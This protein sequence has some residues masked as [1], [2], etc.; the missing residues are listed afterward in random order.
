MKTILACASLLFAT[1]VHA[2]PVHQCAAAASKQAQ[3]LLVFHIG[4]DDRIEIDKDVKVLAPVRNPAN[5]K[6]RFDVLEV[7][8]NVYKGQYRMHFIYA[9]MKGDCVLM[10][11]EIME[12]AS[13]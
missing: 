1:I 6:Q 11:Q 10:G 9:Q 5:G 7:W 4:A 3:R 8:G 12:H 13:L 2:A